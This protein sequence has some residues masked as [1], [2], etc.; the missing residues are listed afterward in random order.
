MNFKAGLFRL[1]LVL[2][3]CWLMGASII[4]RDDLVAT[5]AGFDPVAFLAK[6]GDK[7]PAL[8]PA[9]PSGPWEDYK[10]APIVPA[11]DMPGRTKFDPSTAK[12][13]GATVLVADWEARLDAGAM[14]L[15]P[16][17]IFLVLG[18]S[19]AWVIAGFRG[20]LR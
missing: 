8:S 16:P 6:Y 15:G 20:K 5:R 3:V 10:K 18:L 4:L 1:W 13:I 17:L 7:K 11:E 2:S 9:V 14:V 19:G 12:P